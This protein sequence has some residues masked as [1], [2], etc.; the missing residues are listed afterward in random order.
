MNV[1]IVK[2]GYIIIESSSKPI[3]C[4]SRSYSAKH[5]ANCKENISIKS[6]G[7]ED[8]IR[9]LKASLRTLFKMKSKMAH[10]KWPLFHPS[11]QKNF[12]FRRRLACKNYLKRLSLGLILFCEKKGE[13]SLKKM[14]QIESTKTKFFFL[15]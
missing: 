3:N 8:F 2:R 14:S 1:K 12:T 4:D 7:F 9:V 10:C 11:M 15:K 5:K 13:L 6:L